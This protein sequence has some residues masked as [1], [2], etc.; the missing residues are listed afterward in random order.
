MGLSELSRRSGVTKATAHRLATELADLGLLGREG[1]A[2]HLGWAIFDLGRQMTWPANVQSLIRPTLLDL[3]SATNAVVH[4]AVRRGDE[5]VLVERF[6]RRRET[7]VLAVGDR[8]P[9]HEAA[10]GR[11]FLAHDD[12]SSWI[13]IYS[14]RVQ[15]ELRSIRARRWAEEREE[16][17]AGYRTYAA[18]VF[19][20]RPQEVVAAVSVT[21]HIERADA[22][23]VLGALRIAA[24]SL[25]R[26]A[27]VLITEPHPHQGGTRAWPVE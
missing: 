21:L 9:L 18:P 16:R 11:V 12:P 15:S 1:S 20:G 26:A 24:A 17:V 25:S 2:Y 5:C 13:G 22:P 27:G 8:M 19:G 4:M 10:S 23:E 6:A 7:R 3:Q 14:A